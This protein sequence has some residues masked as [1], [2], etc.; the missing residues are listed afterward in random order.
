[1]RQRI[2]ERLDAIEKAEQVRVLYAAE[3]GSRAWGFESIDSDWDVRFVY[4]HPRDWYLSVRRQRDV[5]ECPIDGGLDA[6]G[7]DVRKALQLF[8]KSNP[9]LLEWLRSPIV[10]RERQSLAAR[11]RELS[12]VFFSAESCLRHYLHM[13]A[14]NYRE[15]L[16][17]E[18]VW[19]KKYFYVLRPVLACCWIKQHRTMPP[20]EFARLVDDQLPRHLLPAIEDLLKRKRAGEEL[21]EGP[22]VPALNAFIESTL[23]QLQES[24]I[25]LSSGESPDPAILD[26]VFRECLAEAWGGQ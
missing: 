16:H 2:E 5:I 13:A 21:D 20:M 22:R 11:L 4:A 9:A 3:S 15:Y 12:G 17:G 19:M 18:T 1:M 24:A 7:W 10:Y 25:A 26:V 23:E 14:R 8:A 6:S